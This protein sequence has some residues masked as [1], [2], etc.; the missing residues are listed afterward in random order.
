MAESYEDVFAPFEQVLIDIPS[1]VGVEQSLEDQIR[2]NH[3]VTSISSENKLVAMSNEL[4]VE[5]T[6][7]YWYEVPDGGK[8][9]QLVGQE[10]Y[11]I[12]VAE[13]INA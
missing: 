6:I 2:K 1:L 3:S 7:D 10:R 9:I 13:L 8:M 4:F 11:I 5:V 12:K